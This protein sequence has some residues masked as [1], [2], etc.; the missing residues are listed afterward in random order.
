MGDLKKIS[1]KKLQRKTPNNRTIS[2][3]SFNNIQRQKRAELV[4]RKFGKG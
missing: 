2:Q 3:A 4:K 1:V